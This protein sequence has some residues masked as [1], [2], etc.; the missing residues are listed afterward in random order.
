MSRELLHQLGFELGARAAGGESQGA[1]FATAPDGSPVLLADGHGTA[2]TG[3]EAID[4]V[5]SRQAY[6]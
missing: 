4:W 5:T 2:C 1:W 3:S 6:R